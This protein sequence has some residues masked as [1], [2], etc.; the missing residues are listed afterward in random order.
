MREH[1]EDLRPASPK[2]S[3]LSSSAKPIAFLLALLALTLLALTGC[4]GEADRGATTPNALTKTIRSEDGTLEMRVPE[5]WREDRSLNAQADLQASQRAQEAYVVVIGDSKQA[6]GGRTLNDFAQIAREN[7]LRGVTD[8]TV[9][10]PT[11]MTLGG[12][13]AIRFDIQGTAED[14]RVSYLYTLAETESRYL[15]I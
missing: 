7:F 11:Q 13:P 6:F 15:Q 2:S 4:G 9:S 8:A 5:P 12:R 3:R 14:V 10:E 1:D